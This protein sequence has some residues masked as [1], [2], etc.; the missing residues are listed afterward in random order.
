MTGLFEIYYILIKKIL[1]DVTFSF[2]EVCGKHANIHYPNRTNSQ[3]IFLKPEIKPIF[4]IKTIVTFTEIKLL[5]TC[6][7]SLLLSIGIILLLIQFIYR[8]IIKLNLPI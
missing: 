3:I 4:H 6:Q 1:Q 7:K 8:I 5:N 2:R